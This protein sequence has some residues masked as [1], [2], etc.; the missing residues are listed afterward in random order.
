V[1]KARLIILTF[2]GYYLPGYKAGGAL[3]TIANMVDHL[4][5]ELEFKIVALDRD[6]DDA[7]PYP[8]IKLNAWNRV[9]KAE[10]F[11]MS[12]NRCS[13]RA[14]RRLLYFTKYDVLYLNSSFSPHFTIKPLL[15][16]RLH[17]ISD[18][19]FII[20]PRGEFSQGAIDLKGFKKHL[21]LCVAKAFGL[22]RDIIWQASSEH[23]E[24]NIRRWFG[25]SVSVIVA[26]DLPPVI[27]LENELPPKNKKTANS[28]KIIFL[29]RISRKKNLDS[30][31]KMLNGLKG[32]VQFNIYG[33]IEDKKYW[34]EC[35][36]II[37]GLPENIKVRYFSSVAHD[38]VST[39]MS[40]HD[41][42]FL[43]TLGENFGHVILEALCAG[44]PV[45][46]SDQTPWLDL[47][48]KGI[49]WDLPL[50]KPGMFREVLQRCVDMN[51]EEYVKLCERARD[52]G[53]QIL[54]DEKVVEENRRLFY[55]AV[56]VMSKNRW[57]KSNV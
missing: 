35:Q 54:Q 45:L 39:V 9:G 6:L 26:Q 34:A 4:G 29:S 17:L 37:G 42:F 27:R 24:S 44:C 38:R 47:E 22:Y 5:D 11:Y 14:F 56:S 43:P 23:E 53:I 49:G 3:R 50:N 52:K 8:G 41:L 20:A 32:N 33:P 2:V 57:G 12:P 40:E 15:L 25:R 28:L 1:K 48:E 16:K 19:Q 46:I 55:H 21:Y 18:C 36:R 51:S 7:N 30:A 31:L 10:V 13:L